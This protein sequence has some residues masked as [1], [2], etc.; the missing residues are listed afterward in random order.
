MQASATP[1]GMPI[2]RPS[3]RLRPMTRPRTA[4][5][6]PVVLAHSVPPP[7]A[8]VGRLARDFGDFLNRFRTG[9]VQLLTNAK[10]VGPLR[11][12]CAAAAAVTSGGMDVH[13]THA[14]NVSPP[15]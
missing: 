3:Y 4:I 6:P 9:T 13:V 1:V 12:V 7:A 11:C 14:L 8:F 5:D 2:G 15:P 10:K